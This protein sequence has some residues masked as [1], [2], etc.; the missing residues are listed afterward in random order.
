MRTK[1]ST[2]CI[3][4]RLSQLNEVLQPNAIVHIW[5]RQA[6][7]LGLIG[8]AEQANRETLAASGNQPAIEEVIPVHEITDGEESA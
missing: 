3:A 7:Q 4:V 1:G 5:R 2:S 8:K 6:D